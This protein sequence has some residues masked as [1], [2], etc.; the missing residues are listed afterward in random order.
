MYKLREL[1]SCYPQFA[2]GPSIPGPIS[3]SNVHSNDVRLW[4]Y[5]DEVWYRC[6]R[7]DL[8]TYYIY[9]KTLSEEETTEMINLLEEEGE[10]YGL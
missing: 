9:F 4:M 2:Y 5:Y 6:R 3:K 7:I 8:E 1:P 10:I